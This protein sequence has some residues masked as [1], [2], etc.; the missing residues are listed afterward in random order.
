MQEYDLEINPTKLVKGEGPAKLMI[1]LNCESLQLNFLSNH[2]NQL[3]SGLQVIT[4]FTLSPWYNDIVYVLQNLQ[5]PL[6]LSD[7][8][9]RSMKLKETNFFIMNQY[10][11]WKDPGGILMNFF[12]GE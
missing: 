4:H 3:Y 7:T 2:S 8:R 6:G 9:A 11:Y 5:V 1:D 10:L 12:N